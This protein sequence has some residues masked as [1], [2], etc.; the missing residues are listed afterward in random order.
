MTSLHKNTVFQNKQSK[1]QQKKIT[2][3]FLRSV[4]FFAQCAGLPPTGSWLHS[5]S[6]YRAKRW[7][8]PLLIGRLIKNKNK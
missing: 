2:S 3:H 4:F 6:N 8:N 7:Q 1:N 5:S